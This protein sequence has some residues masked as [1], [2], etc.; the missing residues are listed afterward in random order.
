MSTAQS[1][2]VITIDARKA[3]SDVEQLGKGLKGIE[4]QGD[5]T[6]KKAKDTSGS[7]KQLG[8]ESGKSSSKVE[9]LRQKLLSAANEGKFGNSVQ[10]LTAKLINF[11]G[12]VNGSSLLLAGA[13]A[14]AAIAG[15]SALSRFTIE[16]AKTNAQIATFSAVS[17]TGV[18]DFQRLAI[19]ANAA[20]VSQEK[21][22]DQL[23]DFNEKIGEFTSIGSGGAVDFFEQIAVKTEGGAEGAKKLAIEMSKMDGVTALQTYVDKLQEAGVNQQQ[24]SFYLESMAS[25]LTALAPVLVDNGKAWKDLADAAQQAGIIIGVDAV[26]ASLRMT[27]Q[28]EALDMQLQG[29]KNQLLTAVMPSVSNLIAL[30]V[31]GTDVSYGLDSAVSIVRIGMNAFAGIVVTATGVVKI[32][33]TT[34]KEGM[35]QLINAGQTLYSVATADSVRGAIDALKTGASVAKLSL[36]NLGNVAVDSGEKAISAFA[37]ESAQLNNLSQSIYDVKKQQQ[38]WNKIRDTGFAKGVGLNKALNPAPPKSNSKS[39]KSVENEAK[40]AAEERWQIEYDYADKSRQLQMDFNK[41][42]ERLRKAG[43]S[44]YEGDAKTYVDLQRKMM[45]YQLESDLNSWKWNEEQKLA[46]KLKTDKLIIDAT[47]NMSKKEKEQRKQSLDDQYNHE[48]SLIK[49]SQDQRLFQAKQSLMSETVAMME[50]YRLEREEIEK[51]YGEADKMRQKLLAISAASQDKEKYDR[52][53]SATSTWGQMQAAMMGQSQQ[54]SLMQDRDDKYAASDALF[55]AQMA[56]AETA[57]AREAIWQA[58]NE[59]MLMIEKDYKDKSMQ[60]NMSYGADIL[61]SITSIMKNAVGEQSKAYAAAFAI[62]KGFAVAQSIV[63]I[64]SA[65]AQA[66]AAPFPLNLAQYA[67]VASQTANIVATI[68]STEPTGFKSGGY[69]GNYGTSQVAGV[70]HG[71]EY[72]LNAA[73]T[74]RVGVDTLD[75]INKGADLQAQRVASASGGQQVAPQ[76][77][78]APNIIIQDDR[79]TLSNYVRSANGQEDILYVIKRNRTALGM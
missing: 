6:S 38:E 9:E 65:L 4:A 79:Q 16:F 74:R 64:Q 20:G 59:R 22:S 19:A 17:G 1:N 68:S 13:F 35:V 31:N 21:L 46:E 2:L 73:A 47:K 43:L 29:M 3:K 67:T 71:Q 57:E 66:M 70:V 33:F 78:V 12:E 18:E 44:K 54:Y 75:A 50:R 51:T 52:Y 36:K 7:I 15:A 25:D 42:V 49:L 37:G 41:E 32:L 10:G 34:V 58:H 48:L 56:L 28:T 27:A 63:A 23:K 30:F 62:Q 77:N 45:G 24:M 11:K 5:K 8:D 72:V 40:R 76:V 61:G 53:A 14:T 60:L 55:E 26:D 69:T 39:N